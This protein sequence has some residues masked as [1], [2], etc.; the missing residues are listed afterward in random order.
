MDTSLDTNWVDTNKKGHIQTATP[1]FFLVNTLSPAWLSPSSGRI[2]LL[3]YWSKMVEKTVENWIIF[4][5]SSM[6]ARL[7]RISSSPCGCISSQ[8][9]VFHAPKV[10]G[11]SRFFAG[12]MVVENKILWPV[13]A[14]ARQ[15]FLIASVKS[16]LSRLVTTHAHE[17]TLFYRG[18][19]SVLSRLV[20][21]QHWENEHF[22]QAI[23][24]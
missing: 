17:A 14:H 7:R 2:W 18:A 6:L 8:N 19:E 23:K 4:F 24:R 10:V 15:P 11:A 3:F 9:T 12:R 5:T 20:T 1:R 13:R 21:T 16:V 22:V